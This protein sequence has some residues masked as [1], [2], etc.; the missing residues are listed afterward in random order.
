MAI[1][2]KIFYL[3]NS[4]IQGHFSSLID[5]VPY[6]ILSVTENFIDQA[7]D[8]LKQKLNASLHVSLVDHVYHAIKRFKARQ[9][10]TNSLIYEIENLYPQ[11]FALAKQFLRMVAEEEGVQLPID[12]AGFIAMHLINAEMN[13]EMGTTI[14]IMK[15]V[16]TILNIIKYSV[17]I[18][19][20]ER[21]LNF[22]RLLM[23]LKFFVQ[24]VMKGTML[25]NNDAELYMMVRRKYPDAYQTAAKIADYMSNTFNIELPSEEVLYLMIHLNRLK[26][27][28]VGS[29]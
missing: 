3:Q 23:H 28:D 12:E 10:I 18:E 13:E 4:D 25:K 17:D 1:V 9:M 26:T 22:Y 11:E 29:D 8:Q 27:R 14:S 15:E 2:D 6:S 5:E 21:S 24:R 16:Y 19:Y 20:D 7:V